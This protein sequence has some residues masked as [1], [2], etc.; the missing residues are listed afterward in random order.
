MREE[1]TRGSQK[2][3]PLLVPVLQLSTRTRTFNVG[4]LDKGMVL[5]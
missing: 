4:W 1:P 5:A 2:Q 3:I